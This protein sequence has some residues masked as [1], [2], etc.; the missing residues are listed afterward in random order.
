MFPATTE[1]AYNAAGGFSLYEFNSPNGPVNQ[2]S[3]D[4][5]SDGTFG[6]SIAGVFGRLEILPNL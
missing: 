2:V 3:F 6:P 1:Q 4:R 5:P